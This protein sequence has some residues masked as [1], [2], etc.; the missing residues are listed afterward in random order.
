MSTFKVVSRIWH[1][2]ENKYYEA[3]ETVDLSHLDGFGITALLNVGAIEPIPVE[4]E[5]RKKPE[6]PPKEGE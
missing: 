4:K 1:T 3:G 2:K 5:K 6:T